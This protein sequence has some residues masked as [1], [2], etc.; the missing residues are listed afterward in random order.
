L[1][2]NIITEAKN[3][4]TDIDFYDFAFVAIA[5]YLNAILWT[6]DKILLNKLKDKG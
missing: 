6:G 1:P 4:V 3:L 5:N 2:A